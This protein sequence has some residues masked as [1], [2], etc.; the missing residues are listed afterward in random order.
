M[1][2]LLESVLLFLI[3]LFGVQVSLANY[4]SILQ[5]EYPNI[6]IIERAVVKPEP[7]IDR[8]DLKP[9][10]VG[11]DILYVRFENGRIIHAETFNDKEFELLVRLCRKVGS[12]KFNAFMVRCNGDKSGF[13]EL[14]RVELD[15]KSILASVSS[16]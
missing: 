16:M 7:N 9:Y 3:G 10:E 13:I 11:S 4:T 2:T 15:D 5:K 12:D 8:M 14:V 6:D 1:K